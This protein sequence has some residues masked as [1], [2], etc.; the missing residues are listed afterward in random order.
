MLDLDAVN[1]R[2]GHDCEHRYHDYGRRDSDSGAGYGL[3]AIV[4]L[5]LC[6]LLLP[7]TLRAI[8]LGPAAVLGTI[9]V[10][11]ITTVAAILVLVFAGLAGLWVIRSEIF[12]KYSEVI[13]RSCHWHHGRDGGC[14]NYLAPRSERAMSRFPTLAWIEGMHEREKI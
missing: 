2:Y 14:R 8:E 7:L 13:Y 4:A 6:I 1:D 10:F 9:A 12:E 11:L 3:V 5:T